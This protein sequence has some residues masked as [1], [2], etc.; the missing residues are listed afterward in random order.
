MGFLTFKRPIKVPVS[1]GVF[2]GTFG[3]V[4][5][6]GLSFTGTNIASA[7]SNAASVAWNTITHLQGFSSAGATVPMRFGMAAA[8]SG[9]VAIIFATVG[10]SSN[11]ISLKSATSGTH[12]G[13]TTGTEDELIFNYSGPGLMLVALSSS[14]IGVVGQVL[15]GASS[16]QISMLSTSS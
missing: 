2:S 14:R 13:T 5:L 10:A 7:T 9:D 6:R 8:T 3:N 11:T 1:T 15:L 16:E 12:F 4:Q